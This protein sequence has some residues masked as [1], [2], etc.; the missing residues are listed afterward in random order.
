M[1]HRQDKRSAAL[2]LH[3]LTPL[4]VL[5]LILTGC[6]DGDVEASRVSPTAA[7]DP[8]SA[9]QSKTLALIAEKGLDRGVVVIPTSQGN[10]I[11]WRLRSDDA[12]DIAF[13]LY[14]NGKRINP[15]PIRQATFN[16]DPAGN[17]QDSY[18]L[19]VAGCDMAS[20]TTPVTAW[21]KPY[22]SLALNK[23]A[24]GEVNGEAYTYRANDGS[25]ADL[26]GDGRYEIL[27]KWDPSNSHDNSHNGYTGP[28]LLDAYTQEG[29]QLWRINLGTNIR[30]GAHYTQFIAYDFDGDG[31]AEIAMKTADGSMDGVGQFIGDPK[32]D[33]RNEQG[34][35]LSGPEYLTVFDGMTGAA[36]ATTDFIPPR[37]DLAGWG[38]T[39]G[40]RS[41]RFLAGLAW[42]DGE[43]PSIIMSRGYYTRAVI[44][45]WDWRN[46]K[47]TSRWVFDSNQ[48]SDTDKRVFGQGAHSL[49]VGDVD[50]DGRD[51]II[52]GAAAIDDNGTA[53]YSTGLGHGDALHMSDID[54]NHP[55]MEVFMVHEDAKA[56][57]KHGVELHDAATGE[58]LWS[59]S[60]QGHDVGR[61]VSIDIDP[62]FP[63]NENWGSVGGLIAADGTQISDKAPKE[64][65]FAIYWDGD[66]LRE[67]LDHTHIAKWNIQT[68][69]SDLLLDASQDGA[70]SNNGTKGNPVLSA[71]IFGDW[72]EEVIW[73]SEDSRQLLIYSSPISTDYRLP[74]LMQE[75]QYRTA[76]AWQNVAYNQPPHTR[77]Y[78]G[79][80]TELPV[81]TTAATAQS[82]KEQCA[83]VTTLAQ[84]HSQPSSKQ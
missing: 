32:A 49:S 14:K 41:D 53:L 11:S 68:E 19:G 24:D 54:P 73:R 16:L 43:H 13:D 82:Q 58:I 47:L 76:V 30:A 34:R 25:V 23:P 52:Y 50:N 3:K 17:A 84:Q 77:F 12:A 44:T 39:Y 36:L 27:L 57:G 4:W 15:E 45:A 83:D 79:A 28:V 46:G 31:K 29:K 8:N 67:L 35:I 70:A 74:S 1:G 71:D 38:D 61:G 59:R 63:G 26:D 66:L 6:A 37:G 7:S 2:R 42:L 78:L 20:L 60:G 22:L 21:A 9:M 69:Q 33:F 55:G 62:R 80:G 18:Q 10:A 64:K 72:R 48:G 5:A 40:N 56:Y 75:R 81:P 65:N 51:E